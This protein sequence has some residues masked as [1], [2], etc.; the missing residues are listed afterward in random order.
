M[1]Q[2]LQALRTIAPR[3]P[4]NEI[5]FPEFTAKLITDVFDALISANIRQTQAY[6]ELLQAVSKSLTE[7]INDTQDD[8][9]GEMILQFLSR[10]LPDSP[11]AGGTKVRV[12]ATLTDTDA[13]KLN[14]ALTIPDVQENPSITAAP[15]ANQAALDAILAAVA[16]RIAADKYSLL[17]EMV[18]LGVLRLVVEH[19]VIET[20][21]T[22]NTY[23][24]SF[25]EST[26][27]K[28]NTSAFATRASAGTGGLTSL[29]VKGSVST[30]FNTLAI[31]TAKETNRDISGSQ[32]QIYGRVQIDFK[33]DYQP[34]TT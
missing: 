13:Q 1:A 34:L 5:Q 17:K 20:R 25:Y 31:S 18:K 33:T 27:N 26:S 14:N 10:V 2:A 30:S 12:G 3:S 19:G 22:F 16:K 15:I 21:L 23:K 24:S 11:E 6:V 29:F 32:V 8:I 28:Y 4:L 9:S 7:Y